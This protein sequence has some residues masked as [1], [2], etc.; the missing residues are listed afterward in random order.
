MII[1]D[2]EDEVLIRLKEVQITNLDILKDSLNEV[3]LVINTLNERMAN[4]DEKFVKLEENTS[5]RIKVMTLPHIPHEVNP[6]KEK[7]KIRLTRSDAEN[8]PEEDE[9][10]YVKLEN[11]SLCMLPHDSTKEIVEREENIQNE[12]EGLLIMREQEKVIRQEGDIEGIKESIDT[13]QLPIERKIESGIE[14]KVEVA[15]L[16]K[17]RPRTAPNTPYDTSANLKESIGEIQKFTE[18]IPSSFTETKTEVHP[19]LSSFAES[20]NQEVKLPT[21]S[22]VYSI[23]FLKIVEDHVVKPEFFL[24]SGHKDG[25]ILTW[26]M[27]NLSLFKTF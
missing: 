6:S 14:F 26:E 7:F 20:L 8:I 2:R 16:P 21:P 10:L 27:K 9:H 12:R 25:S 22:N 24:L 19:S 4:L 18:S 1:N 15:S 3:K 5:E 23:C 17:E 13:I 11:K